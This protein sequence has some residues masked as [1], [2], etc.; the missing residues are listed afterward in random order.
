MQPDKWPQRGQISKPRASASAALGRQQPQLNC[1]ERAKSR[2]LWG[3]R[4]NAPLGPR[5]IGTAPPRA[6]LAL[7]LGFEIWPR[8]GTGSPALPR[9]VKLAAPN[10]WRRAEKTGAFLVPSPTFN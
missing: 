9:C 1:P 6:A 4:D 2:P 8:W 5:S 3:Q 10:I 7:A